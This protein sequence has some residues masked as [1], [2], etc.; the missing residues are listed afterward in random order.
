[1]AHEKYTGKSATT[2]VTYGSTTI[3]GWRSITIEEN[4]RPL[5]TPIDIT[6][7]GD[8]SYQFTDDP[9]GGKTSP[10]CTV[11]IEGLLSVTDHQDAGTTSILNLVN[12]S[13]AS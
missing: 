4:G 11:T 8:S 12:G 5:P 7:A 1:M 10:N 6:I 3:P 2:T 13:S 9:L